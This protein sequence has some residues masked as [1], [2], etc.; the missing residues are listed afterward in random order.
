MDGGGFF[1]RNCSVLRARS[2]SLV[3]RIAA[4]PVT[5][6][7]EV[8]RAGSG[9]PLLAVHGQALHNT[10][11][12]RADGAR[13][14]RTALDRLEAADAERAIVVGL[15]LGYHVEALADR[16]PG[17]IEIVEPDL[18]LWRV[19]LESRDLEKVLARVVSSDA[20]EPPSTATPSSSLRTRVLPHQPS[21]LRTDGIHR[22]VYEETLARA[23]SSGLQLRFLVVPPMAGG[24][25]PIAGYAARALRRL[26]HEVRLLDLADFRESL[27]LLERF[28][29]KP[30]TRARLEGALCAVLGQGIAA[31]A[32]AFAPDVVLALAQAPLDAAALEAIGRTGALRALWFVEDFRRFTYWREVAAHYDHVFTI[33]TEQCFEAISSASAVRLSYLPCAFDPAV[34][35]PLELSPAERSAYG[36]DVSFVGAGYHNRRRALLRFLDQDFRIW[37]SEW[38]GASRLER[39]VQRSSARISTEESVQIFNATAVN[40]N[41]HS[42]TYHDDVD[43][44]GDFVNPRTFELAGCGAFQLVDRRRLLPELLRP[45]EEV[46]VADSAAEMREL[47][48]H[49]LARPAEREAIARNAR[50]R[51]LAE[52]TYEHRMQALVAA[53]VAHA[54]DRVYERRRPPTFGDLAKSE[55][56]PLAALLRR[57][58]ADAPFALD[59]IVERIMRRD[60]RVDEEEAIFLFLHQFQEL[61]LGEART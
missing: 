13:W 49:F 59:P 21:L 44:N 55:S 42:S 56:G 58:P 25:L 34:H 4:E 43:P 57:F 24:S 17:A 29:A 41:L 45:G 28:G 14:A 6:G 12:P 35:R 47:A 48:V 32:E 10:V 20:S 52:H 5:S 26:G 50:E 30:A 37:G 31:A 54:P 7:Y 39:V 33:Q 40:L 1:E 22:R 51:A 2:P 27:R 15:G 23:S 16:F 38:E 9:D 61:Y 36:S 46:I 19:A 11:D 60:G 18:R 53:L 3:E 8:G